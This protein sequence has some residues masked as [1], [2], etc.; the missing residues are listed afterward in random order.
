M[1]PPSPWSFASL[2]LNAKGSSCLRARPGP[3]QSSSRAG[4]PC[5]PGRT[6]CRTRRPRARRHGRNSAE[7]GDG[8]SGVEESRVEEVRAQASDFSLN[9]PKRSTPSSRQSRMK[10]G[11]AWSYFILRRHAHRHAERQR[12]RSA[13]RKAYSSGLPGRM[14]MSSASRKLRRRSTSST[15]RLPSACYHSYYCDA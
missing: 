15:T 14:R 6:A 9:S 8:P 7:P 2:R 1:V 10:S 3:R 4:C 5:R 12:I 11:C 13:Q